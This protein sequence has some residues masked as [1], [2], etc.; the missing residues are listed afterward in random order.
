MFFMVALPRLSRPTYPST[1]QALQ[2]LAP[3]L[4]LNERFSKIIKLGT[5]KEFRPAHNRRWDKETRPIL[6]AFFHARFFLEM[7][8]RYGKELTQP[9]VS[10]PSGWAA[11]LYLYNMR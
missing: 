9:P 3:D 4:P 2:A 6:E 11:F 1:V 10:L 7:A 8:F 5:G